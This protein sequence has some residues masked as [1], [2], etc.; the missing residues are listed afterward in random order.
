MQFSLLHFIRLDKEDI[1][2]GGEKTVIKG[3]KSEE[4]AT[5]WLLITLPAWHRYAA[6]TSL[7]RDSRAS[8]FCAS[9]IN[10][11]KEDIGSEEKSSKDAVFF[12]SLLLFHL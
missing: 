9:V 5:A 3:G 7:C 10:G 12:S 1:P 6:V 4:T 8:M 2:L 11:L